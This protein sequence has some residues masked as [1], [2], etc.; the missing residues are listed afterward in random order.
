MD[1]GR[2]VPS[3]NIALMLQEFLLYK[4]CTHGLKQTNKTNTC[5][6]EKKLQY[7]HIYVLNFTSLERL[8]NIKEK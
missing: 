3:G 6:E 5:T 1:W 8:E 7:L 2:E 4:S